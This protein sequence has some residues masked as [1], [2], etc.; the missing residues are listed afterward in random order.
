M[1]F[2]PAIL[3]LLVSSLLI[4]VMVLYAALY[5][6]R[7]VAQWDI[8]SGSER[9]LVLERRTYFVATIVRYFLVIQIA[10][11]FLLI[12]TA[13]SIHT[14]FSG[15]MCAVGVFDV[16]RFGF[17]TILFKLSTSFLAGLWLIIDRADNSG[18]DYPLIKI[19]YWFLILLAPVIVAENITQWAFFIGLHPDIITSCC[20]SLFSPG[21]RGVASEIASVPI[22]P[23]LLI[24]FSVLAL[25][26]C[27]G[28][29]FIVRGVGGIFFSAASFVAGVISI[30]AIISA[31]SVYIYELPSH[32][33][34][35]CILQPEY[36][37]IGYPMYAAILVGSICGAG[38]GVC[39]PFRKIPSIQNSLL[40]FGKH[41]AIAAMAAFSVLAVTA[42][43]VIATSHYHMRM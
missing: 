26:L 40:V 5:G 39:A 24:F 20:G 11:L 9:Q 21:G 30:G 12:Y 17:P 1:I 36:H 31:L 42:I 6:V 15:T 13:D 33:C 2:H 18:A 4:G 22:V 19:K 3:S 35:F 34:P 38:V 43:Q 10:S 23:A 27:S 16:N 37:F 41:L 8:K 7:I 28:A 29:V 25:T 32:H 14:L